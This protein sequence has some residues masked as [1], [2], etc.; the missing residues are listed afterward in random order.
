[1]R[2]IGRNS[3]KTWLLISMS[4]TNSPYLLQI[5]YVLMSPYQGGTDKVAIGSIC[6][7]RCVWQW[8]NSRRTRKIYIM[9]HTVSRGLLCGSVLL[10]LQGMR[11]SRKM[12]KT[13]YF[14]LHC[15][16][17]CSHNYGTRIFFAHNMPKTI[18]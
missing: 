10:I 5:S 17:P 2:L 18:D 1:M 13:I 11:H 12:N 14:M 3:L 4:I 16:F 9:L 15:Q 7:C 6:G 8:E